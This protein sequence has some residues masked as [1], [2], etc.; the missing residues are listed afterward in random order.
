MPQPH[1][2]QSDDEE[3]A[4][5]RDAE[6][7]DRLQRDSALVR[8]HVSTAEGDQFVDAALADLTDWR[9]WSAAQRHRPGSDEDAVRPAIPLIAA[10]SCYTTGETITEAPMADEPDNLVLAWMR[11]LDG[12]LD[13]I[14][15]R[16]AEVI[17]RIGQIEGTVASV[18][19]RVDR[20]DLRWYRI[21]RRLDLVDAPI[22]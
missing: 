19:R 20:I 7:R 4:D 3:T 8:G 5:L 21:E 13:K 16:L 15:E 9:E 18:S 22:G 17:E 6:I 11:R 14:D 10:N 12:R 2:Q 1:S